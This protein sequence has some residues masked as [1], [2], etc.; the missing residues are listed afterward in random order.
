MADPLSAILDELEAAATDPELDPSARSVKLRV[1]RDSL[2]D[3][4]GRSQTYL[5]DAQ[6]RQEADASTKVRSVLRARQRADMREA[7]IELGEADGDQL[8]AAGYLSHEELDNLAEEGLLQEALQAQEMVPPFSLIPTSSYTT[9]GDLP[10]GESLLPWLLAEAVAGAYVEKLHPR[11]RTGKWRR[12]LGHLDALDTR[13]RRQRWRPRTEFLWRRYAEL[14]RAE[15]VA[16]AEVRDV[17]QQLLTQWIERHERRAPATGSATI[18]YG[19]IRGEQHVHS[20]YS[21]GHATIEELAKEAVKRGHKHV[22]VSD[23]AHMLTPQK[24]RRQHAEIDQ[25]NRKYEG[26]VQIVKGVEAN[27]DA[28][29]NVAGVKGM[30]L[31]EFEHVNVGLHHEKHKNA[32]QRLMKALDDPSI[33]VL[34]HPH[35]SDGVDYDALAKKAA[36]KGIPLEVNGRDL[37]RNSREGEAQKMI[38]AAKKYGAKL[39]FASDSHESSSDF[40]DTRYA[41][42]LAGQEGVKGE[43]VFNFEPKPV[44]DKVS[45]VGKPPVRSDLVQLVRELGLDRPVSEVP[46]TEKS[47]ALLG[48]AHDTQE[49]YAPNGEYTPARRVLHEKLLDEM[50]AGLKKPKGKPV[51]LFMAGGGASGKSVALRRDPSL[52]PE[53]AAEINPDLFKEKLP[54]WEYLTKKDPPDPHAAHILHE[55]SATLAAMAL[56]R[57]YRENY[58]VLMDAVG[59]SEKGKFVDK[60]RRAKKAGYETKVLFV[61]AP[62]NIAIERNLLRAS[63]PGHPDERRFLPIPEQKH[64]HREAISR[65]REWWDDD[66]VDGWSIWRTVDL[67][68]PIHVA[69][70]GKGKKRQI[71]DQA[72]LEDMWQKAKEEDA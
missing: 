54:E 44:E 33:H 19:H 9:E 25:L 65:I 34:A 70:G 43:D 30:R 24:V 8:D 48:K 35:T 45:V 71:H 40:T 67:D 66:S 12:K 57:A 7:L 62:T 5:A 11:D 28:D 27:I 42:H 18:H 4:L 61:D 26:K 23:H 36:E 52:K 53:G 64:T 2:H 10:E 68:N 15:N 51:V 59:N 41:V 49:L 60:I 1:L 6:L 16:Q 32:Q 39:Q 13:G 20:T 3:A 31:D 21:D 50:F 55:E 69:E 72:Q 14:G 58:N 38:R 29:G 56:D 37:L 47:Q 17:E 63:T 22:I 46:M